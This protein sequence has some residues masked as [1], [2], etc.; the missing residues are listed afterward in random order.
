MNY[1]TAMLKLRG[2]VCSGIKM[3]LN[4][5]IELMEKFDNPQDKLK[6]IHIAGTNGKGSCSSFINSV[7][8]SQGYKVGL[9][10]SPSI[11]NF[12]ERIRINNENIKE[13]ILLDLM[14]EVREK[15]KELKVFPADFELITAI[16]FLYFYRENCDFVVLEVGLGGRLDATNIIKNPLLT[17]I[18]SISFDH[19]QF[20]GNTLESIATEKA[21]I[22][23]KGSDLILYS[24]D[25]KVM[26]TILNIAKE[27]NVKYFTNDL[28]KIEILENNT[29]GEIINYKNYKNLKIA[30]LGNHQIK[31]ATLSLEAILNLK[32]KKL[33]F[34]MKVFIM[35]LKMLYGLVDLK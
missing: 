19:Q 18:T 32:D 34:Q 3:G 29:N 12:E 4:N 23:K 22:I 13:D 5:M 33:K 20:L 11:F 7:L 31:N 16:A 14:K 15:A 30:L 21:G 27:K 25:K 17:L 10:T 28:K 26:D 35:D 9:F 24:Q 8:I 2:K 1:E 6:I